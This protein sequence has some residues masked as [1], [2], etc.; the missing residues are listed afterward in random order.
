[1]K[2]FTRLR[3]SL[4]AAAIGGLLCLPALG[5]ELAP[6][7]PTERPLLFRIES[8]PPSYLFGTIHLPDERVTTLHPAVER[9][10]D[11]VDAFYAELPL[12]QA[13]GPGTLRQLT[14]PGRET[15]DDA[16]P[17]ELYRRVEAAFAEVGLPFA[18]MRRLKIW[19]VAVQLQLLDHMQTLAA[20]KA[21]DQVLY[22]RAQDDLLEVG[23]LEEVGE[24]LEVF[25][26]LD[27]SQQVEMLRQALVE[28]DAARRE[29]R[30]PL[31]E[32]IQLYLDGDVEAL[33][34]QGANGVSGELGEELIERLLHV[35]NRRMAERI[36]AHLAGR[37]SV[38]A[39]FAVGAAH[40][41]G[42]TGILAL[43]RARGHEVTRLPETVESVEARIRELE[44]QLEKQRR[45]LAELKRAG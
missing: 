32:L 45:R 22:D 13:F 20:G 17:P 9:A 25:D 37:A 30:D 28:R 18:M 31:E 4:R 1:M 36:D 7:A 5:Q 23:G 16:L 33:A 12:D 10:L 38:P 26:G 14:L 8:D 42:P 29:D 34:Q 2:P 35:R 15:L 41:G 19:T 44:V 6:V 27:R 11:E 43:L 21:L 3:H 24:Q 40:L 39:F